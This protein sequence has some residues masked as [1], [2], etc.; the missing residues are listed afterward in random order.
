VVLSIPGRPQLL[1]P[2]GMWLEL[3]MQTTATTMSTIEII[4]LVVTTA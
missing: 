4:E 1:L 3:E 2:H